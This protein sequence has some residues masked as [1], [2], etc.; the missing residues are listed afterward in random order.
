MAM[1]I[2]GTDGK[3]I[4]SHEAQGNDN[5]IKLCNTCLRTLHQFPLL[6]EW[7]PFS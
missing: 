6:S 4:L 1:T 5:V 3:T 7:R 2:E